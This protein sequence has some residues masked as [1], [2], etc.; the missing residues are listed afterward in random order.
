MK[1]VILG[2]GRVG[3]LMALF[4]VEQKWEV[5]VVDVNPE[6]FGDL[7][8]GFSGKRVNGRITDEEVLARADVSSADIVICLTADDIANLMAAQI[9]RLKFAKE[10]VLTRVRDPIKAGAYKELGVRTIC[11]TTME[12][13]MML[14]ELGM[15]MKK[16][17]GG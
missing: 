10:T 3:R 16:A 2:C 12:F 9:V 7:G 11:P 6:A 15:K 17:K 5:T 14:K 13:E 8:E 4:L 1:A